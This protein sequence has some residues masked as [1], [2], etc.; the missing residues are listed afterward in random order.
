VKKTLLLSISVA[1]LSVSALGQAQASRAYDFVQSVAVNTHFSYIDSTYYLQSTKAIAAIKA[2]GVQHVRDGLA[3]SWVA[4][5]LYAIYGQLARAGIHPELVMPNPKG[6]NPSFAQI[7]ALLPNYPGVEAIEAPNEYDRSGNANWVSDL[8]AFLPTLEVVG[9]DKGL[10]V[11][12][13]SLTQ[14]SSYIAVGNLASYMD[15]NNLHAYWGGRNPE[16]GGWGGYD[17]QGNA[18]GSFPFEFDLL[19]IDGPGVPVVV[20]ESGYVASNTPKANV[21]PESVEAIYEP[22][23]LLHAWN[24]GV[25][26]TYVYELIDEPSSTTGFG[27]MRSDLTARPAYTALANLMGLLNDTSAAFS[28]GKLSYSLTGNTTGVETTLLQK[29]D[30]SYWLALWLKGSIYDVNMV[31][32]TPLAPQQVRLSVLGGARVQSIWTLDG[33]G[34]THTASLGSAAVNLSISSGVS[35]L[36]IK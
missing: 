34:N 29:H 5:N 24:K 8:H 10:P 27:L 3:Y 25:R 15:R 26:R 2:L 30:G 19:A 36:K 16:T 13:P 14:P 17:A 31:K 20:T 1:S 23:L 12:G 7:E 28:P 32:S 35:L 33:A 22:R 4:P 9:Q 6:G 21:I 18:Y 11:I